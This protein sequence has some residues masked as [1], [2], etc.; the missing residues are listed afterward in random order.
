M[1]ILDWLTTMN[2][3]VIGIVKSDS[4]N[5]YIGKGY[6]IDEELDAESIL[7]YGAKFHLL[8]QLQAQYEAVVQQ[9]KALQKEI[10][11]LKGE[12]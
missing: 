8:N 5:I 6:G 4:G 12:I 2:G 1:Q 3:D 9:N 10:R 11:Q 7:K